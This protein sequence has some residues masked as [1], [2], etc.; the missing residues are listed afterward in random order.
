MSALCCPARVGDWV[1]RSS[2]PAGRM[3]LP[4]C[5]PAKRKKA[6]YAQ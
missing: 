6:Q 3:A 5:F 1:V 4:K 2:F